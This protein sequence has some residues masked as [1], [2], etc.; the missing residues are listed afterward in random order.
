MHVD[1]V[2][3][4]DG[5]PHHPCRHLEQQR[6]AQLGQP[7]RIHRQAIDARHHQADEQRRH[8]DHEA[9]NWTGDAD[10]EERGL[11]RDARLDTDERAERAGHQRRR[12]EERPRCDHVVVQ[13]CHVVAH[14]MT[15]ENR[16]DRQ[17][18]PE[19]VQIEH[20][21]REDR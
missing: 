11:V 9:G 21:A 8:R 13:A 1:R 12:Q 14:L 15:A 7:A 20:R 16:E 6:L 2:A 18:V 3:V 17:A 5:S 4:A 19:A 10:V